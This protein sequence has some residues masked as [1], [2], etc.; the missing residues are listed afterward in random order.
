MPAWRAPLPRASAALSQERVGCRRHAGVS[1]RRGVKGVERRKSIPRRTDFHSSSPSDPMNQTATDATDGFAALGLRAELLG[2]LAGLG[3]EEPTPIQCEA[4]PLLLQGR[5]LLGQAATGTGKTAAFAL[6]ILQRIQPRRPGGAAGPGPG[7]DARAGGAGR[8]GDRPVRGRSRRPRRGDLRRAADPPPDRGAGARR[9]RRRRHARTGGRSPHPRHAGVG[10]GRDGGA[11][12]GRRDAR[13]GL[14]RGHR[15]DPRGH[16]GGAADGALLGD[17]AAAH[18]RHRQAS[19]ARA[20]AGEDR[21]RC[22]PARGRS[23]GAPRRLRRRPRPQDGGAGPPARRRDAR[24]HHRLLPH[25]HRG[26]ASSP[27]R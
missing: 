13:H 8:R 7:A 3:Y 19:P 18:R 24:R 2:A 22:R 4:V 15:G 25:A 10:G 5:D 21:P 23:A 1:S 27:R 16:P 9:P 26:R 20:G 17:D 6:P 12:R 14:R 11:R